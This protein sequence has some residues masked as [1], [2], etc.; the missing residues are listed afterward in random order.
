MGFLSKF[1]VLSPNKY[2][3]YKTDPDYFNI[4]QGDGAQCSLTNKIPDDCVSCSGSE[5]QTPNTIR[6][7][8]EPTL[9]CFF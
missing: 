5:I 9:L 1:C 2:I 8:K 7:G 3:F 6:K 4:L